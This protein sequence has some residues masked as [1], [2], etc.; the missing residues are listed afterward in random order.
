MMIIDYAI[1]R[2]PL[3]V[4][5]PVAMGLAFA[6]RAGAAPESPGRLVIDVVVLFLLVA[7]FRLWD[8][9][10]DRPTDIVVHPERVVAR[11]SSTGPFNLACVLLSLLNGTAVAALYGQASFLIWAG[12]VAVLGL[13][14]FTRGARS[15]VGDHVRL[16]KYPGCVVLVAAGRGLVHP[17]TALSAA[18]AVYLVACLYE[19]LHDSLSPAAHRRR[20]LACEAALLGVASLATLVFGAHA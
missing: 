19:A 11:S 4:F 3:R 6:A 9:L 10:A 8:D 12:L 15:V 2:L 17:A 18:A 14:Y 7:Q 13:W 5:V 20:L 1:E 16:L